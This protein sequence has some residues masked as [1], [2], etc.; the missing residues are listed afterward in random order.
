MALWSRGIMGSPNENEGEG[1]G[2]R[3]KLMGKG[4]GGL[5]EGEG[6][7]AASLGWGGGSWGMLG[8]TLAGM[9]APSPALGF[10]KMEITLP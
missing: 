8:W 9:R 1:A 10:W 2:E 5:A 4:A 3:G 7:G 6:R